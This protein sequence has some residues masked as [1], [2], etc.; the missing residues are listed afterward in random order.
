M[1]QRIVYIPYK[2]YP[3]GPGTFISQLTS[4]F[5]D[6][7]YTNKFSFK[8]KYILII[9]YY[10]PI[11]LLILKYLFRKKILLRMDGMFIPKLKL[12]YTIL[13]KIITLYI[14]KFIYLKLSD[15]IVYQGTFVKSVIIDYFGE[16]DKQSFIINNCIS[17]DYSR[18]NY[19]L[20]KIIRLGFWASGIGKEQF[21]L[22]LDIELSIHNKG[23]NST[24]SI[25]GPLNF[26]IDNSILSKLSD[27][28]YLYGN[29]PTTS[30]YR[31]AEKIDIFLMV[32]GSPYPNTLVETL[33]LDIPVVGVDKKGNKE[34]ITEDVGILFK[35]SD[36]REKLINKYTDSVIRVIN[37][38]PKFREHI[39]NRY[40]N[41]FRVTT[42]KQQYLDIWIQGENKL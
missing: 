29:R 32:K 18:P 4:D 20:D 3:G 37:Q 30:V 9:T 40:E 24:I 36:N 31:F 11:V 27:R 13:K 26:E 15:Y 38:Y 2:N 34:I 6:E 12:E 17:I 19:K 42:M 25:I 5:K 14:S 23:Y 10:N 22:L 1:Q 35:E 33:A 21:K 16:S 41:N 28:V 39:K 7:I 8:I